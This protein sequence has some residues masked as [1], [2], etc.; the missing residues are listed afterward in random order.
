MAAPPATAASPIRLPAHWK[1]APPVDPAPLAQALGLTLPAARVLM[2]R[3]YQDLESATAFLRPH[4]GQLHAPTLLAGVPEAAARLNAAIASGEKILLYGDYDVDGTLAVVILTKVIE[5]CGGRSEFHVPH[6]LKEGY[7]M[8]PEVVE[9]AAADGVKLIISVDT[10][11]RAGD[12]VKHATALGIECIVTDHHLPEA[13]LP[14]ALAVVN[15]NR[16]D[17]TYPNKDLCGA[18]VAFKLGM[19]L[20]E[21]QGWPEAKVAR[22]A[23][24]FLKLVAMA[25]VADVVP[26][27]GENRAIVKLGLSGFGNIHNPGLRALLKVA[28]IEEGAAPSVRQVGFQLGPRIN[29][30]GRM[31]SARQVVELFLTSDV[32]RAAE[33]AKELDELNI[34]RRETEKRILD[35]ILASVDPAR[36]GL[37]LAGE[38]WHRGVVGIVASRVVERFHRP[39][40]VLEI[41]RE[42][43]VAR[44][45]GRSIEAFHL[46]DALESMPE[47]FQKFGGHSHAAGLT[48]GLDHLPEFQERFNAYAWSKLTVDDFRAEV[49]IDAEARASELNERAAEDIWSLG[50]FGMGNPQPVLMLRGLRVVSTTPLGSSGKHFKVKMEQNG[51]HVTA[52]AWSFDERLPEI[53]I[54]AMVDAAVTLEEDSYSRWS[55]VLRDVRPAS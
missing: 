35:E 36:A 20:M 42:E 34:E 10:G 19:A 9:R 11:I 31:E 12:V 25:T 55:T 30:A 37:V 15:P 44:G 16:P 4:A 21:R 22:M 32:G 27:K 6:R 5:V 8:R 50:P 13:E 3:G 1:I 2:G 33:I 17:C 24:S 46:L 39:V 47:L 40:F 48:L 49:R 45:S 38:G 7:G 53:A 43:G 23:D 52:K 54:G 18:A 51:S 26:L 14:P 29:A 28:G 41:D